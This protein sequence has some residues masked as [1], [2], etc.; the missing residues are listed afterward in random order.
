[1]V[2]PRIIAL[3]QPKRVHDP[4]TADPFRNFNVD[5]AKP[6]WRCTR[7]LEDPGTVTKIV[8]G[9]PKLWAHFRSRIG[10]FQ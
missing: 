8:Q 5:T 6:L 7:E 10:D 2:S 9:W 1:M 3:S 4:S